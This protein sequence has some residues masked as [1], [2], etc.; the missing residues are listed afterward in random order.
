MVSE[1]LKKMKTKTIEEKTVKKLE[2]GMGVV[3]DSSVL[4]S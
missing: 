1:T 4:V 2:L 3:K